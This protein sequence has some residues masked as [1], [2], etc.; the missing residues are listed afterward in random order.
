MAK[1]Q[2]VRRSL[3]RTFHFAAHQDGEMILVSLTPRLFEILSKFNKLN[4]FCPAQ[5][6][7]RNL[8]AMGEFSSTENLGSL[9]SNSESGMLSGRF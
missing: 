2:N 8:N 9:G 7:I 5:D 4:N 6:D 3:V 1:R